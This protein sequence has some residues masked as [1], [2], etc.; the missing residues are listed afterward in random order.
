MFGCATSFTRLLH[1]SD[2][3]RYV[4]VCVFNYVTLIRY[5]DQCRLTYRSQHT[6]TNVRWLES[7]VHIHTYG[8]RVAICVQ[9][10]TAEAHVLP[11]LVQASVSKDQDN[12]YTPP[13]SLHAAWQGAMQG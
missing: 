5:H 9:F 4:C 8:E 10:P 6:R 13:H 2:I 11:A 1:H 12:T 3:M 7:T